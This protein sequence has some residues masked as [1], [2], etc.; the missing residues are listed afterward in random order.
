MKKAT[1]RPTIKGYFFRL[2]SA[3]GLLLKP[4]RWVG[5]SGSVGYRVSLKEID[6]K[7]DFDGW[8]YGYRLNLFVGHIWHDWHRYHH[9]RQAWRA[10]HPEPPEVPT[11]PDGI[12]NP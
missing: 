6:Y 4:T 8:Y 2:K 5:I 9:A 10:A 3:L 12:G 1:S 11:G 7:E